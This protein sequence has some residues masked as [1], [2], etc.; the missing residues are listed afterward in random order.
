S[1]GLHNKHKCVRYEDEKDEGKEN[2]GEKDEDNENNGEE[3]ES[4]DD[5]NEKD[6]RNDKIEKENENDNNRDG[7]ELLDTKK[8]TSLVDDLFITIRENIEST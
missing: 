8:K 5:E 3:D 7:I 4:K 1:Q 2:V 6:E